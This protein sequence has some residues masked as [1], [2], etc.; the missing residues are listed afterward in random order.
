MPWV[1]CALKRQSWV[2]LLGIFVALSTLGGFAALAS[3]VLEGDLRAINI[4][5]LETLHAHGSP[6]M[7]EVAMA[8]TQLGSTTGIAVLGALMAAF[9][10]LRRRFLD[11]AT[12][13]IIL[14]GGGLLTT[15]LKHWFK[16]PRPDLYTSLVPAQGYTFPSGH[17]LSSVCLFGYLAVVLVAGRPG[18]PERWGA[19]AALI[20]LALAIGWS[21]LYLGVHW[22]S[23]V[24]AGT[25]AALSW[26]SACCVAKHLAS[27]GLKASPLWASS[28]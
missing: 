17:T 26:V 15:T 13:A 16:L 21:R 18:R 22:F 12:L 3:E 7:D 1:A 19:G 27:R 11:A 24:L 23:D 10:T 6:L 2:Y 14:I 5:V 8:L 9:F 20:V 4:V 25:L 28:L